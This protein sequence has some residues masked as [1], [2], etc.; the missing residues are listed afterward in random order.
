M[1]KKTLILAVLAVCLCLSAAA[2][3]DENFKYMRG[4]LYMMMVEHPTLQFNAQIEAVFKKMDIPERFNNHDLGVRVIGFTNDDNQLQNIKVWGTKQQIAKRLVSRWFDRKKETGTFDTE[5]LRERGH[6][7]ATKID[8]RLAEQQQRKSAIL[9]DLGENLLHHTYW[10]V[11]DIRYVNQASFLGSIKEA[12]VVGS[13]LVGTAS[14]LKHTVTDKDYESGKDK[15]NEE[16]ANEALSF[17][18]KYKGFKLKV[19]SYLFRLKWDEEVANTFYLNYYTET[20]DE[21][22]D[23]VSAFQADKDLFQLEYLGEV[24]NTSTKMSYAG[25]K[26]EEDIVRKV[27]TRAL[28]K[29]LADLQHKFSDFR[30]KAPLVSNGPLKAYVGMKEDITEKSRFEVLEVVQD[31]EGRTTYNR[32]GIIRPVKG[33]IWD[34]RYMADEEGS[35]EAKLDGTLFEKVS[36]SD[37]QPGM[38]IRETK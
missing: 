15:K 19:T 18:D 35:A 38:L 36:G 6:Y 16:N 34:N 17:M 10:V 1:M 21:E 13:S 11:H 25:T 8:V 5:L 32:V 27:C 4:S 29:N 33:K 23:K 3:R 22:A 12:V 24:E 30:I 9:E 26:T 28:D 14:D 31:T 20:P 2:Q 7:S 37:F